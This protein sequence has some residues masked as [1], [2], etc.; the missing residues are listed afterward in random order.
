MNEPARSIAV[1]EYF[2]ITDATE[3]KRRILRLSKDQRAPCPIVGAGAYHAVAKLL[4]LSG[5]RVH[6]LTLERSCWSTAS[7]RSLGR[8]TQ[9]LV[10][11][12]LL[13]ACEQDVACAVHGC[14]PLF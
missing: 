9:H 2:G 1:F 14:S 10:V 11:F 13:R 6:N 4:W 5:E 12:T 3:T 7:C 8:L